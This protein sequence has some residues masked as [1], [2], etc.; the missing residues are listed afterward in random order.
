[1]YINYKTH[2]SDRDVLVLKSVKRDTSTATTATT[3]DEKS[4]T[5]TTTTTTTTTTANTII[6]TTPLDGKRINTDSECCLNLE[7]IADGLS[8][9]QKM[10]QQKVDDELQK[11]NNI[12]DKLIKQTG[13]QVLYQGELCSAL[14]IT[15]ALPAASGMVVFRVVLCCILITLTLFVCLHFILFRLKMCIFYQLNA[16]LRLHTLLGIFI[17]CS[18]I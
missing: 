15:E 11:M 6:S 3:T 5:D 12:I 14:E 7:V 13:V 9:A 10:R 18:N 2:L 4:D 8:E 17:F 16:F 1:M